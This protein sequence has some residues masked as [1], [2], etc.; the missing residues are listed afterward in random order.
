VPDVRP[1]LAEGEGRR[2]L[3]A[4]QRVKLQTLWHQYSGRSLDVI[5]DERAIRLQWASEV[6]KRQIASFND[7]TAMEAA[8][9]ISALNKAMGMPTHKPR[10][11]DRAQAA[12]TH[13]RRGDNRTN[14]EMASA[15]DLERIERAIE[16]LGW[17]RSR[18][19]AWLASPSSPL[20]RKKRI[21]TLADCNQVWW[22]L[23]RLLQREG[24]WE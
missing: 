5:G 15:A 19:D 13:G 14:T 21:V 12:G 4:G 20:G 23:K 9:A 22:A 8:R 11:R 2:R 24:L 7:L 10:S 3:T 16:R 1:R 18:F 17:D 6:V